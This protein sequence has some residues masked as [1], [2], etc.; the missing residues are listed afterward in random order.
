MKKIL[1]V[2][3][4]TK[5]VHLDKNNS[6]QILKHIDLSIEQGEFVTI[7]GPSG[8]GKTT[9]L[10]SI[11]GMDK[12]TSGDVYFLGKKISKMTEDHLSAIRLN[13][14]GFVFQQSQ[15]LKNLN[16]LDNIILPGFMAKRESR[17]VIVNRA[18]AL[19]S[20]TGIRQLKEHEIDQASGGQ[21]QRVAI[22]RALIND[23][24]I[25]FGDEPTGALNSKAT[26][27][28][29]NILVDLNLNG[30]TILL[31]T[32]DAKVAARSERVLYMADGAIK[33]EKVLGKY[34]QGDDVRAREQLLVNWLT[35]M[36]F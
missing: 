12:P 22:C 25:L 21:L 32:H 28:V 36:G 1:E 31:V 23:P 15:L 30:T 14:M 9:L 34:R 29:M 7:M 18:L 6:S 35:K 2:K 11:S 16:I 4:L 20:E 27:D 33:G 3:Q 24:E 19:M 13:Y 5:V 26:D 17:Q 10:Y 8:S